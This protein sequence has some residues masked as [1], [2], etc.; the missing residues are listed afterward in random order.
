MATRVRFS[1]WMPSFTLPY[2]PS[3]KRSPT[4]Y[5]PTCECGDAGWWRNA[6]HSLGL[7]TAYS[8]LQPSLHGRG[9]A[10]PVFG[11]LPNF[12]EA[13]C[14][15]PSPPSAWFQAD[16]LPL[17]Y[18]LGH[19]L[20][21]VVEDLGRVDPLNQK[22]ARVGPARRRASRGEFHNPRAMTEQTWARPSFPTTGAYPLGG[23]NAGLS[24]AQSAH[25]GT[26]VLLRL[27]DHIALQPLLPS[28]AAANV[29]EMVVSKVATDLR[30]GQGLPYQTK[31]VGAQCALGT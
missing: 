13:G 21:L 8:G 24:M 2:D 9:G 29:L 30:Q 16:N 18:Q 3:P 23:P 26:P 1:E 19:L 4:M 12:G 27:A 11:K 10:T 7:S 25:R 17:T 20:L 28:S 31:V 15:C 6:R 5:L 22:R 14:R